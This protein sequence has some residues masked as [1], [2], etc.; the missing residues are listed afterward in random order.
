MHEDDYDAPPPRAVE[1]QHV[2]TVVEDPYSE[3]RDLAHKLHQAIYLIFGIVEG[4]IIIR[5]ILRLLGANPAADFAAFVYGITAPLLAPFVGMFG[6]PQ[7][8]GS[9]VEL[10]SI[11]AL[12]VYMLLA[13]VLH[14]LVSLALDDHR[15]AVEAHARRV[16]TNVR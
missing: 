15:R 11:V 6:N 12:I 4:V 1:T 16:D 7:F 2:D 10:H 8:S 3:R 14:R 13:W 5:F 9:V